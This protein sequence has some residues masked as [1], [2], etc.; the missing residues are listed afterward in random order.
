[1]RILATSDL[2]FPHNIKEF[3]SSIKDIRTDIDVIIL[4]GDII[5]KEQHIYLKKLYEILNQKFQNVPILA[6]FGNNELKL[7]DKEDKVNYYKKNYGFIKWLNYEFVEI[8]KYKIYGFM[9][10]PTYPPRKILEYEKLKETW[11]KKLEDFLKN[12][13]NVILFTHYGVCKET[14][15]GDPGLPPFLYSKEIEEIIKKYNEKILL[16]IH[17]HAHLSK[18]FYYKIRKTEIYNVAFYIHKKPIIFEF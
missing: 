18:N 17:G 7:Y 16:V 6:T 13:D 3:E 5:D 15:I 2:H 11:I 12:N 1:M 14:I 4:A 10:F 8:E 9:G